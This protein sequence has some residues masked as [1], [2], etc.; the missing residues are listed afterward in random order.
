MI[1]TVFVAALITAG[2]A[3]PAL[4]DDMM[5]CDD[6]HVMKVEE[7]AKMQKGEN[8]DMAMKEVEM[9]KAAMKN[10]M[11]DECKMHLD[12]AMKHAM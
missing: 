3:L 12:E 1:R 10:G 7:A 5:M 9:A 6:A 2:M 4:A 11:Q 8:M